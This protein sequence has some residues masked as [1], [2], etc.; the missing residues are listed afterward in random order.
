M[1]WNYRVVRYENDDGE[2]WFSIREAYYASPESPYPEMLTA[3]DMAPSAETLEGLR[4]NLEQME[5]ALK[6]PPL[7]AHTRL[8]WSRR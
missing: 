8:P 7:D 4:T 5:A 2:E 6:Q 3:E 1:T